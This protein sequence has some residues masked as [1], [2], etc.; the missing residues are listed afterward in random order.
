MGVDKPPQPLAVELAEREAHLKELGE[1]QGAVGPHRLVD[2]VAD[3]E[4][5]GHVPRDV[6][7]VSAV[8]QHRGDLLVVQRAGGGAEPAPVRVVLVELAPQL[9]QLVPPG[10]LVLLAQAVLLRDPL[11][12]L[13][14]LHVMPLLH[15]SEQGSEALHIQPGPVNGQHP[16]VVADLPGQ[17]LQGLVAGR[18]AQ[19]DRPLAELGQRVLDGDRA[20]D[21]GCLLDLPPQGGHLG[22]PDLGEPPADLWEYLSGELLEAELQPA[23]VEDDAVDLRPLVLR[24]RAHAELREALH[25]L[26]VVQGAAAVGVVPGECLRDGRLVRGRVGQGCPARPPVHL[27][28]APDRGGPAAHRWSPRHSGIG[29]GSR[30]VARGPA[31]RRRRGQ[32]AHRPGLASGGA[33]GDT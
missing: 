29:H 5:L 16:L 14:L 26:A 13:D 33:A 22:L 21:S 18:R 32:R 25:E 23:E 3:G 20:A 8:P 15:N 2:Q 4:R 10:L 6:L 31:A 30:P 19:E 17:C 9:D 27:G 11:E 28:V 7:Q 1:A 24:L 12:E